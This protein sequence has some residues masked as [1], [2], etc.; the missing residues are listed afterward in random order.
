[1]QKARRIAWTASQILDPPAI[2]VTPQWKWQ[3]HYSEQK[4]GR[5]RASPLG[6]GDQLIQSWLNLEHAYRRLIWA[7]TWQINRAYSRGAANIHVYIT[8]VP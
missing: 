6:K 8:S 5:A 4:S 1:M 3:N 2:L 7:M